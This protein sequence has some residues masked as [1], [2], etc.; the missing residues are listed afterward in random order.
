M[1]NSTLWNYSFYVEYSENNRWKKPKA[2]NHFHNGYEIYYLVENDVIYFIDDKSYLIKEG[3]V[4]VI[5]PN[6]VHSTC[7]VNDK[8]RKRFLIYVPE[9]FINEF[10]QL[11]PDLLD[12]LVACPFMINASKREKIDKL[13][14]KLLIEYTNNKSSVLLQ[15]TLLV[16]MLVE[17]DRLRNED[18]EINSNVIFEKP[19]S[20]T[21]FSIA[22]YINLHFRENITLDLLSKEFFLHPS[23][24]SRSFKKYFNVSFSEYLKKVRINEAIILLED[25]NDKI[26]EIAQKTG[27]ESTSA[28]CRVFKDFIGSTPLQYRKN[29][30][31]RG[32]RNV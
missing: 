6:S 30:R 17:L 22:N 5:P 10:I 13:F 15:K 2:N 28:F 16:E 24:I 4:V 1:D 12:R 32:F 18:I 11:D 14:N 20:K 23:Y 9:D 7:P 3:M 21:I 8:K 31:L 26:S 29:Q 19:K 25:T 27:F